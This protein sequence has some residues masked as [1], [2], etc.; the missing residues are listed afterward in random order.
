MRKEKES[1]TTLTI[2][3]DFRVPGTNVIIEAGDKVEVRD[4][5]RKESSKKKK[6]KES[7]NVAEEPYYTW[8][9]S[10]IVNADFTGLDDEEEEALDAF[11]NWV[12]T[13]Y[14]PGA[15]MVDM[16]LDEVDEFGRLPAYMPRDANTGRGEIA[17]VIIHY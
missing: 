13:Q 12:K 5:E 10:A 7:I 2:E 4:S 15:I 3:E 14:G 11:E 17:P 16:N 6:Q 8:A 9:A 1:N